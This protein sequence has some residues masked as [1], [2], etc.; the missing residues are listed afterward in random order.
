MARIPT[1]NL[2]LYSSD[3]WLLYQTWTVITMNWNK[4]LLAVCL[5]CA[6]TCVVFAGGTDDD[7]LLVDLTSGNFVGGRSTVNG[8]ERWLGIP[9][10]QPPVGNLRFKAPVPI[11]TPLQGV[12]LATEFGDS[13]PQLPSSTTFGPQSED[14]L[15]LNVWRPIGTTASD[16]L[17]VLVWFYVSLSQIV[18]IPV[19][20]KRSLAGRSIHAWV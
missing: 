18:S 6:A 8:T 14:C 20:L 11:V 5:A 3:F 9:F 2:R 19:E 7:G 4:I 16:Q 15:T 17:P 13:C 10:A 1:R 12:Q